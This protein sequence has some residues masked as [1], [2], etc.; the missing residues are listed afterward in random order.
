MLLHA[1]KDERIKIQVMMQ[2]GLCAGLIMKH[3]NVNLYGIWE[4]CDLWASL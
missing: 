4:K 3:L 1:R 2:M